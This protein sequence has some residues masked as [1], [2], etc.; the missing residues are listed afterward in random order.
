VAISAADVAVPNVASSSFAVH[1][2]QAVSRSTAVA[3]FVVN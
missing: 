2:S 3:W 1:L